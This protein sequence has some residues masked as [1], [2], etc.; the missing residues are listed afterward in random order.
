[1]KEKSEIENLNKKTDCFL[2][3]DFLLFILQFPY[4][5]TMF[6]YFS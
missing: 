3:Y 5:S 1:M 4:T 6:F 2:N